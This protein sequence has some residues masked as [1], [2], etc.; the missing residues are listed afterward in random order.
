MSTPAVTREHTPASRCNSRKIIRLPTRWTMRPDTPV[1]H[2]EQFLVPNQ[3]GKEPWFVDGSTESP[4]EIPRKSRRTLMSP[5]KCEISQGSR[6]QLEIKTNSP[7][8]APEQ[9]PV[10]HH[11]R[12]V[13]WLPLGNYWNS[14]RHMSSVYRNTNFSTGTRGKLHEHH[15]IWRRELIPRILLNR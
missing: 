15:I 13:A 1:L 7:A 3:T 4:P 6:N 11:T 10:P 14:L 12:Q 8:L 9:F 2:A 5:H